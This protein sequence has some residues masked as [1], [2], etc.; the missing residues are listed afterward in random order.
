MTPRLHHKS[1]ILF[2]GMDEHSNEATAAE[3]A[4]A[5]NR[6]P[7][8]WSL[9]AAERLYALLCAAYPTANEVFDAFIA[10]SEV[11]IEQRTLQRPQDPE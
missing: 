1:S 8:P 10:E 6:M 4:G 2:P 11:W 3:R 7:Y 5:L 9:D